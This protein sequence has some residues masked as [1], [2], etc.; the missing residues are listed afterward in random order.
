MMKTVTVCHLL[1]GMARVLVSSTLLRGL[2]DA[3]SH[4]VFRNGA[5][6]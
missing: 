6:K 5:L 2:I 3:P 4:F 1:L